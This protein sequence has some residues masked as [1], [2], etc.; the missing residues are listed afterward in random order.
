MTFPAW[1]Q[2]IANHTAKFTE[3][4]QV[5]GYRKLPSPMKDILREDNV[6]RSRNM[7]V[8]Q[9]DFIFIRLCAIE[10]IKNLLSPTV[11]IADENNLVPQAFG[12]SDP[13]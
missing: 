9:G 4:S 10:T 12:E 1:S 8:Q 2:R 3:A 7:S 6:L 13:R 5:V 11:R